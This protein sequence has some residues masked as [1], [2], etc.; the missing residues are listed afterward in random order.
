MSLVQKFRD[1]VEGYEGYAEAWIVSRKVAVVTHLL[2]A[3][4]GGFIG[5][6]LH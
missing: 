4:I 2:A 3:L 5:W 6:K 1:K